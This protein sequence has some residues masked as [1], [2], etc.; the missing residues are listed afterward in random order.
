MPLKGFTNWSYL[1]YDSEV[2]RMQVHS[3]PRTAAN[4]AAQE[5]L[6]GD[7]QIALAAIV[8]GTQ[9]QTSVG[10]RTTVIAPVPPAEQEA[11]RELKALV[12]YYDSTTGKKY[13]LEIPSPDLANLDP[14]DKSHFNIGDAGV[15]DAFIAAFEA[16]ALSDD[17]NAVVV[18]EMTLVGR[19][20]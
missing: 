5:T 10:N 7:L 19:N 2:G 15:I 3:A 8:L 12:Q 18:T 1:D 9:I 17:G 6:E 20:Q 4:W 11:Q 14:G 13:S 16:Y